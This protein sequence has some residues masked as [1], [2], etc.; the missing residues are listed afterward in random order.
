MGSD[1]SSGDAS[2]DAPSILS[3]EEVFDRAWG[4]CSDVELLFGGPLPLSPCSMAPDGPVAATPTPP[5]IVV[6]MDG[7]CQGALVDGGLPSDLPSSDP[8]ATDVPNVMRA[9]LPRQVGVGLLVVCG[10][11]EESGERRQLPDR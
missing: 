7:G 10:S 4:A 9:G 5:A 8:A 3:Q 2:S 11:R 1:T 6:D